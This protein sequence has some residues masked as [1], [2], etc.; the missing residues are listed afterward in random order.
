MVDA[1]LKNVCFFFS[2]GNIEE[3]THIPENSMYMHNLSDLWRTGTL[4]QTN[5]RKNRLEVCVMTHMTI[6]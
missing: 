4:K 1:S 6:E 2:I 3:F 5:I